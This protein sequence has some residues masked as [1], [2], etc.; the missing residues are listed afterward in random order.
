M[1]CIILAGGFG[2]RL[3]PLSRKNFP[4]Q[5]M[6]LDGGNS[7]FQ[8]TITRNI[9]YCD[10]FFIVTSYGYKDIVEG[11]MKQFQGISYEIVIESSSNGTAPALYMAS[12][13]IDKE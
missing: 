9:P 6:N 3:W 4:K 5:F 8:E 13:L 7:L 10:K 1:K 12:Q 11:Q 2:D